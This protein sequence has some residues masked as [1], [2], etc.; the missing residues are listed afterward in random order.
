LCIEVKGGQ[1]IKDV[2][3]E[4][5]ISESTYFNVNSIG[6]VHEK[7]PNQMIRIYKILMEEELSSEEK[8]RNKTIPRKRRFYCYFYTHPYS[9]K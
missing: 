4:Y 5:V 7:L 3:R 9:N 1:M 6:F 8:I 2:C